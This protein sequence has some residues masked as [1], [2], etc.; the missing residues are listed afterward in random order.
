M[1]KDVSVTTSHQFV[2]FLFQFFL[3][4]KGTR[5]GAIILVNTS[6]EEEAEERK[7]P[8]NRK[9]LRRDIRIRSASLNLVFLQ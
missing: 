3:L 6:S 1:Y 9:S 5:P 2:S 8:V 4:L 7:L